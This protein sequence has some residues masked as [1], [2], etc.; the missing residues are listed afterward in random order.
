MGLPVVQWRNSHLVVQDLPAVPGLPHFLEVLEVLEPQFQQV[1]K[2]PSVLVV[3]WDQTARAGLCHLSAPE[4]PERSIREKHRTIIYILRNV[5]QRATDRNDPL[6]A[7][8][9]HRIG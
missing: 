6:L 2:V 9:R 5:I 7:L 4:A 1:L 8:C 3:L